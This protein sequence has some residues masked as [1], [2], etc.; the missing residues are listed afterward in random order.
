MLWQ[1]EICGQCVTHAAASALFTDDAVHAKTTLVYTELILRNSRAHVQLLM[2]I[3]KSLSSIIRDGLSSDKD[4]NLID[5]MHDPQ[6]VAVYKQLQETVE[7]LK[8]ASA[9]LRK[10]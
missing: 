2:Q 8:K 1:K 9:T 7:N 10:L 4:T 5:F 3:G 6:R